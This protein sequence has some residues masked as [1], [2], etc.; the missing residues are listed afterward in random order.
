VS[1]FTEQS[2][3]LR[4]DAAHRPADGDGASWASPTRAPA[5]LMKAEVHR[6]LENPDPLD[7]ERSTFG[8][9]PQRFTR[10]CVT[11][12]LAPTRNDTVPQCKVAHLP[13]QCPTVSTRL[14]EGKL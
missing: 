3:S 10:S 14:S 6:I 13:A 8:D 11:Q 2:R 9:L 1:P 5:H 7:R 4:E 12:C